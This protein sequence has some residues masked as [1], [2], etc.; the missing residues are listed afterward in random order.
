MIKRRVNIILHRKLKRVKT[1]IGLRLFGITPKQYNMGEC[2]NPAVHTIVP[3]G[4]NPHEWE[5]GGYSKFI[6]DHQSKITT[7]R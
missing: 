5:E 2:R 7:L 6:H 3:G 1:A 4:Y